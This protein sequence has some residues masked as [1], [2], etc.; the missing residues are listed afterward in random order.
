MWA[1]LIPGH[2]SITPEL[3]Q[4]ATGDVTMEHQNAELQSALW[5][6]INSCVSNEAE[7]IF[8]RAEELNGLDAWLKLARFID[9]GRE[10]R[11]EQLRGEVTAIK[12]K[13]IT[14]LE[15]IHIGIT[16]FENKLQEYEDAGGPVTPDA[17]KKSDLLHVLPGDIREL[18]C[19]RAGDFNIDYQT[20]RDMITTQT[21]TILLHRKKLPLHLVAQPE[22]P[23]SEDEVQ[24]DLNLNTY[25]DEEQLLAAFRFQKRTGRAP[26]RTTTR[27][28]HRETRRT[29]EGRATRPAKCPNCNGEHRAFECT[30][31]KLALSDRV[32]WTCQK[33][34]HNSSACPDKGKRDNGKRIGLVADD[35]LGD[36]PILCLGQQEEWNV[37]RKGARPRPV[38][39]TNK[40]GK[41]LANAFQ[42]LQDKKIDEVVEMDA[43]NNIEVGSSEYNRR[44]PAIQKNIKTVEKQTWEQILDEIDLQ[45]LCQEIEGEKRSVVGTECNGL[46]QQTNARATVIQQHPNVGGL[47]RHSGSVPGLLPD[48]D[49]AV[50]PK[51]IL[52]VRRQAGYKV[53]V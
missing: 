5:G 29:E 4:E 25:E 12:A 38:P 42:R 41:Y 44:F 6:F 35:L 37:V 51:P 19:W 15:S 28:V 10:I 20:F 53:R 1:E 50:S 16:H 52:G 21:S 39:T 23:S 3:L 13:A 9:H 40:M 17:E 11:L 34:G 47:N 31:P 30:K 22:Q 43:V 14:N 48:T 49:E 45:E 36:M 33:K 18:L 46:V 24:G 32:C 7:A 27:P 2:V 26:Q 8:K